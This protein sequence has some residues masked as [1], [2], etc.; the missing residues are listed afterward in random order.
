[1]TLPQIVL[2]AGLFVIPAVLLSVGHRLRRR[3]ARV[4]SAFWGAIFAHIFASLAVA[5]FSMLPPEA[6]Q[7]TDTMR[8]AVGFWS[9]LVAPAIGAAVGA[10][11]ARTDSLRAERLSG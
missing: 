8:G 7:S 1:M 11:R 4:Q 6:W 5:V 3:S 10:L 9:L 2:L